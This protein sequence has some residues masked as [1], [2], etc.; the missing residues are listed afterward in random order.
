VYKIVEKNRDRLML[1]KKCWPD[2]HV[3]E[4]PKVYALF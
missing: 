1:A 2:Y 4:F 3:K